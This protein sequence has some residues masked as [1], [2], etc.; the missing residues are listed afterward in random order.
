MRT[1][2]RVASH[3]YVTA[4][5]TRKV[6][7]RHMISLLMGFG[8]RGAFGAV[9]PEAHKLGSAFALLTLVSSDAHTG[10]RKHA[11]LRQ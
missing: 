10:G 6:T 1:Q 8:Q 4:C 5:L 3:K 11:F 2:C 9:R 7:C